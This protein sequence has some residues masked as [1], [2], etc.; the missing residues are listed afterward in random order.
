[1][2]SEIDNSKR[3]KHRW[4]YKLMLLGLLTPLMSVAGLTTAESLLPNAPGVTVV[5]ADHRG[6][7]SHHSN[8][9]GGGGDDGKSS[10][11]SSSSSEA[12]SQ[13]ETKSSSQNESP[14]D[15]ALDTL[16]QS[17]A[18]A[19]D[20]TADDKDNS[21]NGGDNQQNGNNSDDQDE[22]A[23]FSKI[24]SAKGQGWMNIWGFMGVGNTTFWN[25]SNNSS[26]STSFDSLEQLVK[27]LPANHSA[28]LE[29]YN[30]AYQQAG[31]FAYVMH[32][33]GL[34]QSYK[35]GFKKVSLL[36]ASAGTI[37]QIAYVVLANANKLF[38]GALQI[39]SAINPITWAVKGA[40]ASP[41]FAPLANVINQLYRACR[42]IGWAI[43]GIILAASLAL[44]G[45]GV[46]VGTGQAHVGGARAIINT[47]VNLLKRLFVW[48]FLPVFCMFFF[49]A[50]VQY[51][52][53]A[54]D[55]QSNSVSNYAVF[56]SMVDYHDW[57]MNSRLDLP[58]G[59]TLSSTL[60]DKQVKPL[61]H[62]DILQINQ[63]GAGYSGLG[64][65]VHA[66]DGSGQVDVINGD[67]NNPVLDSQGKAL[68]TA[69]KSGDSIQASD[70]GSA[71]APSVRKY[72]KDTADSKKGDSGSAVKSDNKKSKG[73]AASDAGSNGGSSDSALAQELTKVPY[74]SNA[75]LNNGGNQ[76]SDFRGGG[77]T[78]NGSVLDSRSNGGLSTLGMYAYLETTA[79][80]NEMSIVHPSTLSNETAQPRHRSVVLVGQGI[81]QSGNLVWSFGLAVGLA[82]LVLGYLV[83]TLKTIVESIMGMT[84][85]VLETA[86]ASLRGGV[87]LISVMAA[88]MIGVFG[89]AIMYLVATKAYIAV[90]SLSDTLLRNN[91]TPSIVNWLTL[92]D[93][94]SN[95][96]MLASGVNNAV[97]NGAV[98]WFEGLFLLWVAWLLLH[99]RGVVVASLASLVEETANKIMATFGSLT[100]QGSAGTRGMIMSNSNVSNSV[101][102][103]MGGLGKSAGQM[104]MLGAGAQGMKSLANKLGNQK[105]DKKGADKKGADQKHNNDKNNNRASQYGSHSSS[106]KR[107]FAA[108]RTANNSL[109]NSN[110]ERN[111]KQNSNAASTVARSNEQNGMHNSANEGSGLN[112]SNG[113]Q[114][115]AYSPNAG[116]SS[117]L[118][119]SAL[120]NGINNSDA[121][122]S[123]MNNASSIGGANGD[124]LSNGFNNADATNNAAMDASSLTDNGLNDVNGDQNVGD[125]LSNDLDN[126]M[127]NGLQDSAMQDNG[128]QDSTP[129]DMIT[130][131]AGQTMTAE[132]DAAM[133]QQDLDNQLY[134]GANGDQLSN[135]LNNADATN[136]ASSIGGANGDQLANGLNN[137]DATNNAAMDS[138]SLTD[139]GLNDVNGDQN[140][141]DQLSNDLDN[142]MSDGLQDSAMQDTGLQDTP[143]QDTGMQDNS[144]Q[145]NGMQDSTP[146]DMIT[147]D[148]GQTM[149][150][151]Q[152]A[153]MQQQDLASQLYGGDNSS[154]NGADN[155]NVMGNQNAQN[156]HNGKNTN[157][158]RGGS[159]TPGMMQ[160]GAASR[161]TS[162]SMNSANNGLVNGNMSNTLNSIPVNNNVTASSV[163]SKMGDIYQAQGAANRANSLAE[164]NPS[165]K[166]LQLQAQDAQQNLSNLQNGAMR[167]YNSQ[168]ITSKM[169]QNDWLSS[170]ADR[171][172]MS[173]GTANNAMN[174]VYDAQQK[175]SQVSDRYGA[176]SP[177]AAHAQQEL[178]QARAA[179][180]NSGLDSSVVNDAKAVSVAHAQ[181]S[182]NASQIMNGTWSPQT[183]GGVAHLDTGSSRTIGI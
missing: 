63:Y 2:T 174:H 170:G 15:Q 124:Q 43:M 182:E 75:N 60:N 157:N 4:L 14:W 125:Q 56:G 110:A 94:S 81:E 29:S 11:D 25:S 78:A 114:N 6:G 5:H 70:Y 53:G 148:A 169:S 77:A 112:A 41:Q 100:G 144:M 96:G 67:D 37:E 150:A 155:R 42:G 16:G 50:T 101:G 61:T 167:D 86:M 33:V 104:A 181:I 30:K 151:E 139:N 28:D 118:S 92:N 99:Y 146:N 82:F 17:A 93:S 158:Q 152:D 142:S 134:G 138:S 132:Q 149:T 69:W 40:N 32:T 113:F 58:S 87:K 95:V 127:N 159:K 59:I 136:N 171:S 62:T 13:P 119:N 131:D 98:N 117:D 83:E 143:M 156:N 141:V 66:L 102:N 137:A 84:A 80:S 123:A 45:M 3:T 68:L 52:Q 133:Q 161:G 89:S 55:N 97:V 71:V 176:S 20:P 1:M 47:F 115:L 121:M 8:H 54:F 154:V 166:T 177:Q 76:S 12:S 160:L 126:S 7:G 162:I 145:A 105:S 35:S 48:M 128:M 31:T 178:K 140:A 107:G 73:S 24:L 72:A 85:G 46:T 163:Q 44:A 57:V 19:S 122:N 74:N 147:N 179:A 9:G 168:A 153:A 183:S 172:N 103:M 22:Q 38:D 23:D 135:G 175:L 111:N 27:N 109:L 10:S 79:D 129:N 51:A 164:A 26:S 21:G 64:G 91:I 90:G 120:T 49:D 34:D 18:Q 39:L 65:L 165:N 88:L 173:V 108:E 106:N 36:Y 180:V 116:N 130:N